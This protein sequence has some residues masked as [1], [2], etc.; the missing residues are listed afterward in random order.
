MIKFYERIYALRKENG[1]TQEE[2][3]NALNI[4]RQTVSNWETGSAQPTIDKAI[5]LASLYR[6]SM[7]NLV[8]VTD[9]DTQERS[10]VLS[11]LVNQRAT[12]HLNVNQDVWVSYQK[13]EF[14]NCEIIEVNSGSIRII[15]EE[16]KQRVEKLIFIKDI[17]GFE[18][19]VA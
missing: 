19:E 11:R 12:L 9:G 1:L 4:S 3:A 6:V 15:A 8:G 10:K 2:V 17:L 5:E 14:K 16:K 7:D 18:Q 13:S